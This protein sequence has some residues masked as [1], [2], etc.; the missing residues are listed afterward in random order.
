V[1][2]L[3]AA[4]MDVPRNGLGARVTID[5]TSE[6]GVSGFTMA[7][8]TPKPSAVAP[9][10]FVGLT[11]FPGQYSL[12]IDLP[13]RGSGRYQGGGLACPGYKSFFRARRLSPR[14]RGQ[15]SP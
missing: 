12:S 5:Y 3:D 10:S 13:M 2:V 11:I 6:K 1:T 8:M 15:R 7:N 4:A 14:F 9:D